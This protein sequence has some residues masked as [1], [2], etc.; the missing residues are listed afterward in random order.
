VIYWTALISASQAKR[1]ISKEPHL[2]LL[3]VRKEAKEKEKENLIMAMTT[4]II[5]MK[6]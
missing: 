5:A 6:I 2:L 3:L 1:I 4:L